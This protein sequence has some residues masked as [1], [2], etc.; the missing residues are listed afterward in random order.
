MKHVK[1]VKKRKRKETY[2]ECN[3]K[4]LDIPNP[5][6]NMKSVIKEEAENGNIIKNNC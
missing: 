2:T 1:Q 3:D 4:V 5:E 6:R